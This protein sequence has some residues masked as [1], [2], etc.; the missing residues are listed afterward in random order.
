M[1][2][3]SG[4]VNKS[5]ISAVSM[6]DEREILN[7][8]VNVTNEDI[9]FL[10]ILELG[11][12]SVPTEQTEYHSFVNEEQYVIATVSAV[13]GVGVQVTATIDA[14]AA[15][16]VVVGEIALLPNGD[17]ARVQSIAGNDIVLK[18]VDGVTA[19]DGAGK[20]A[21]GAKLSFYSNAQGEASGT[22]TGKSWGQ[23]K[24]SNQVQIFKNSYNITDIQNSTTVTVE[25]DGQP[26]TFY[27]LAFEALQKFRADIGNALFISKKSAPNFTS[28]APSLVDA[29]GK[30]IQTTS[31]FDQQAASG[32]VDTLAAPTAVAI[33]DI[34]RLNT[35]L[36]TARAPL[37]YM[38]WVGTSMNI[39]YDDYLNAL[40]NSSALSAAGR[41]TIEGKDLELGIDS[42]KIY[43]RKFNKKYLRLLD[44]KNILNYTGA[45][46]F[47]DCMYAS[48]VGKVKTLGNGGGMVDMLRVRYLS[49][50]GVDGRY[51][52]LHFGNL[53]PTPTGDRG[54]IHEVEFKSI[55]GLEVLA[56]QFL[57]KQKPS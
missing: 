5:M 50:N 3:K 30:P 54:D 2:I 40:S 14:T 7:Q 51:R 31:G 52:E 6:L 44:H 34:R 37:E 56:P 23:T 28:G 10:D 25:V 53:A 47:K 45:P 11:G 8:I 32:V 43:G 33:A 41:F 39:F 38:M 20:V 19:I 48:P 18:N 26:Y 1:A 57:V 21:I 29:N 35:T 4:G 12:Q 15:A 17:S 55:Q 42:F 13:S 36:N 24:F 46:Q 49:G 9:S 16:A 22:P 27:K